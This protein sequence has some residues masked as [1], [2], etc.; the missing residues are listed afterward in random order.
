[1][2]RGFV[3]LLAW[4]ACMALWAEDVELKEIEVTATRSDAPT[5]SFRLVAQMNRE[6]IAV[7]PVRNIADLLTYLPGVDVRSRG[8]SQLQSDISMHGG[9]VEQVLVLL[10]GVPLTDIQ[11][12]HYTMNIPV[13]P[14]LI[15]RIEVLQ[16]T[17]SRSSGAFTGAINI[18]TRDAT[19]D[20]YMLQ[21]SGGTNMDAA[22]SLS[23]QW[24]RGDVRVNA[25]AGYARSNG[26]YA[27]GATDKEHAALRN[28]DYQLA[29]VYVQTRWQSLDV[30]AGVQYKDAGLG[31]GYGYASTDQLDAT[32]TVFASARYDSPVTKHWTLS[33]YAVYRGQFDR[34]E[35]HRGT[36]LNRHWTHNAQA[37]FQAQYSSS[38]GRTMVGVE[39][40]NAFIRSTNMGVH[41]RWQATLHAG[42]H[43]LWNGWTA[44]IG[45]AGHYN[46]WC[47][48]YGAG[49]AHIGYT[50]LSSGHVALSAART[51]RMPTWTD[52]YYHAGVQR[53]NVDLKAEKAWQLALNARYA[54]YWKNAGRLLVNADL[55]YRWGEDIIDWTYDETDSLYH[56]TN[57]HR[58]NTFGIDCG[59][60]YHYNDWLR[61]VCLRYAYTTLSLDLMQTGSQYL[62]HLRHK[63]T[64]EINHGIYVWSKG[65]VGADWSLR[66]QQREGSYVDIDGT[67]GH[68]FQPVLL[69][70]GSIYAELP[71]VR[72]ALE[73]T[74]MTNRHYYDYGGILMAGIHGRATVRIH[75]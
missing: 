35:W 28:T 72:I 63:L 24:K 18:I 68:P 53:G 64:L 2:R 38:V 49:D 16:C 69:L 55:Y 50:F 25:A 21:L 29:N 46:S 4:A 57:Q 37:A 19:E 15:E 1:M 32:R 23:G 60:E 71:Y 3:I 47:G 52:M 8:S 39:M 61:T 44:S 5:E 14:D 36:V 67:P 51:L 56:A 54:W 12:G 74:N 6:Q 27:P 22:S 9:T 26:Y 20:R 65:C 62:D 17:A 31:T 58:V 33:S 66:W 75:F 13:S 11:T 73:C 41:N 70:D 59:A 40:Q 30:Q 42:Q 48:W 45:L 10:N 34:Y 7:L 43:F